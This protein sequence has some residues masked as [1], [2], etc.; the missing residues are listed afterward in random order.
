[1]RLRNALLPLLLPMAACATQSP[2]PPGA[3]AGLDLP[4]GSQGMVG[5]PAPGSKFA[6]I[7]IGMSKVQVQ[8]LIGPPTDQDNHITGKAFIPFYFG[9]D[10]S[11]LESHYRSEGVLTYSPRSYGSNAYQ[12]VGITVNSA[13][14]GY[15]RN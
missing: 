4:T 9:G 6:R 1:M 5:T 2:P 14:P 15:I 8:D 3:T 12:L 10:T 7:S 13:E 11:R